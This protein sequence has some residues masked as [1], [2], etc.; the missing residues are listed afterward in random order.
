VSD[1]NST[2][3]QFPAHR[4]AASR[5][6]PSR[7]EGS[8][9]EVSDSVRSAVKAGAAA[10]EAVAGILGAHAGRDAVGGDMAASKAANLGVLWGA[11]LGV[12]KCHGQIPA[13]AALEQVLEKLHEDPHH[14][15]TEPQR[16][17]AEGGA[18]RA[19]QALLKQ[20]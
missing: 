15:I 1:R 6:A 13:L 8:F 2:V 5:A 9:A 3:V 17:A 20:G 14:L 11:V 4:L 7:T 19:V 12:A 16:E 10:A 18:T